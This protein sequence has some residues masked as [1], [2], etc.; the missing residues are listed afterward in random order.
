MLRRASASA[1]VASAT[2][3]SVAPPPPPPQPAST[4]AIRADRAS[5]R[6][7]L[8]VREVVYCIR[9]LLLRRKARQ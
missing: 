5:W 9:S 1:E 2:V 3:A 7:N 4:A 8:E 6:W